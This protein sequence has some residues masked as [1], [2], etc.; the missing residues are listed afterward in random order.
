MTPKRR[1]QRSVFALFMGSAFIALV[2]AL[3]IVTAQTQQQEKNASAG[4]TRPAP[5]IARPAPHHPG[6]A[7]AD[8]NKDGLVDKS[9]A[10]V[11]PGLSANFERADSNRDGKLDEVEF[12]RGLEILQVRR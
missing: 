1:M 2:G 5:A 7:Q 4:G 11:V 6:F 8:R 12:A 3:P 10:G 9:E